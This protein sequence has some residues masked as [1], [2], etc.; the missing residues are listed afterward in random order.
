MS[1]ENPDR[2]TSASSLLPWT[3]PLKASAEGPDSSDRGAGCG[4]IQTD[5]LLTFFFCLPAVHCFV[6]VRVF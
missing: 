1:R 3:I 4:P 6:K 2:E 5:R